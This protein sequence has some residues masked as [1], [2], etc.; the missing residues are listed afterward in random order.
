MS[1][2]KENKAQTPRKLLVCSR[3]YP[4]KYVTIIAPIFSKIFICENAFGRRLLSLITLLLV[5]RVKELL[6]HRALKGN[7]ESVAKS[8][9]GYR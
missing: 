6:D 1:E 4:A 7:K 5:V 2:T 3:M 9:N 8:K